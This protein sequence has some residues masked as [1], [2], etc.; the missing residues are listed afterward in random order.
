MEPAYEANKTQRTVFNVRLT[1]SGNAVRQYLEESDLKVLAVE[2]Q[3][4]KL[5]DLAVYT[6]VIK[7]K[8]IKTE[9]FMNLPPYK[10]FY[11]NRRIG[12]RHPEQYEVRNKTEAE[13]LE[14]E[15]EKRREER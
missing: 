6:G 12:I 15:K 11:N 2:R 13:R 1:A 10:T 3:I 4:A 5:S 9:G 14:K 7:Y 8:C